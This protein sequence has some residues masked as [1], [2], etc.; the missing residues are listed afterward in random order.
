M[1]LVFLQ[2]FGMFL[3]SMQLFISS[4]IHFRVRGPKCLISSVQ[5]LSRPIALPVLRALMLILS[6]SRENG[7]VSLVVW[8]YWSHSYHLSRLFGGGFPIE[9][10]LICNLVGGGGVLLLCWSWRVVAVFRH[11]S[12]FLLNP[13]MSWLTINIR[14]VTCFPLLKDFGCLA[15]WVRLSWLL[16]AHA[17]T[18]SP[19]VLLLAYPHCVLWLL[20]SPITIFGFPDDG[21][22]GITKGVGGGLYTEVMVIPLSSAVRTS[23]LFSSLLDVAWMIVPFFASMMLPCFSYGLSMRVVIP[24]TRGRWCLGPRWVSCR[25]RI[26]HWC[27]LQSFATSSSLLVDRPSIFRDMMV[28]AGPGG[29][30]WLLFML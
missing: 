28:N 15:S 16:S 7:S 4:R 25:Q 9:Q 21:I 26:S 13:V 29:G 5:M 2:I 19:S 27:S 24:S 12:S 3:V 6:S 1:I 23:M 14:I 8:E 11:I 22:S 30:R 18:A 17:S 10:Q 20:K